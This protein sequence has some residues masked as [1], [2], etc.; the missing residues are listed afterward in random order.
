MSHAFCIFTFMIAPLLGWRWNLACT[1]RLL[2]AR[3]SGDWGKRNHNLQG[4]AWRQHVVIQEK[5]F[6]LSPTEA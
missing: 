3:G 1:S 6:Y 5:H 2:Y 4:N